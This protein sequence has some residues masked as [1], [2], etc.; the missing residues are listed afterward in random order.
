MV[1]WYNLSTL[2]FKYNILF[3]L[4]HNDENTNQLEQLEQLFRMHY[5]S[6]C[7][8]AKN[9]VGDSA[10]AEDVVQDMFL[11]IWKKK[12]QLNIN[13][14]LKAYI[15]RSTVNT[16]LNYLDKNKRSLSFENN[17]IAELPGTG[18]EDKDPLVQSELEELI[19]QTI[20]DLPPKCRQ[21]FIMSRFE[22]MKYAEIANQLGIS[23]KTVENQMGKALSRVREKLQPHYNKRGSK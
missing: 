20:Q 1:L 16:A 6:L 21:I 14:E 5:R 8:V 7:I 17:K 18:I 19:H 9:I 13:S 22:D 15:F 12:N 10:A 23:I 3:A 2:F 4:I 11:K